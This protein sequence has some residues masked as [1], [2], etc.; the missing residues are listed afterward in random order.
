MAVA[1]IWQTGI[2]VMSKPRS[3][4]V[5]VATEWLSKAGLQTERH[6]IASCFCVHLTAF[7]G[8][9]KG[10]RPT[11]IGLVKMHVW[12]ERARAL[13]SYFIGVKFHRYVALSKFLLSSS[14]LTSKGRYSWIRWVVAPL[15]QYYLDHRDIGIESDS[16]GT[17]RRSL[18]VI[19]IDFLILDVKMLYFK[20]QGT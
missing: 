2:R 12:F 9:Q 16:P 6:F 5:V 17:S 3:W 11:V 8:L 7:Q 4:P 13:V 18:N 20:R 10:R 19:P 15:S 14:S 1:C